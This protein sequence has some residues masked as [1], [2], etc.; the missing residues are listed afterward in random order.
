MDKKFANEMPPHRP[1]DH[2]IPLK[3]GK[4]PPLGPFYGMSREELIVLKQ[5]IQ[6]NLE[7]GFI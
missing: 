7:K 1:Y 3:E 2:K 5:Y 4:E 6:D